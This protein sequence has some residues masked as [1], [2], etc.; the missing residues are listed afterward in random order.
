MLSEEN[1]NLGR[2]V[3]LTLLYVFLL[4]EY[5]CNLLQDIQLLQYA[6]NDSIEILNLRKNASLNCASKIATCPTFKDALCSCLM[7]NVCKNDL[8]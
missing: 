2:H 3:K 8:K 5:K 6:S 4:E 1:L 7:S